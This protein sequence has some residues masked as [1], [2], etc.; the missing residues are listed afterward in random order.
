MRHRFVTVVF[1]ILGCAGGQG[2]APAPEPMGS[3]PT[4]A[5]TRRGCEPATDSTFALTMPVY[6]A[7]AVDREAKA[8]ERRLGT[9]F[10]PTSTATT[11]Y[12]AIVEF[13]VDA[14]G[15]TIPAT[16]RIVRSTDSQYARAVVEAVPQWRFTPAS[17]AGTPVAQVVQIDQ[18]IQAMVRVSGQ[19][20]PPPPSRPSC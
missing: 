5:S 14:K 10:R 17:K 13:V 8:M 16:T 6:R 19:P 7:C 11:C 15:Q 12:R 3:A 18:W 9:D 4:A 2:G 20:A 1:V